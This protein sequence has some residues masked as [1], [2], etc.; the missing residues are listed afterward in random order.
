[1]VV[2]LKNIVIVIFEY[3]MFKSPAN[4]PK[5]MWKLVFNVV[6]VILKFQNLKRKTYKAHKNNAPFKTFKKY[7]FG[8][9]I[10]K[11]TKITTH[12]DLWKY[13]QIL[14]I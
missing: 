11:Q 10:E 6:D 3:Y 1:M 7:D 2:I 4:Y 13:G 9:K 12:M 8:K 14:T 5:S